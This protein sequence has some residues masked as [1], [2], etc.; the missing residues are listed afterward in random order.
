LVL[1]VNAGL[2]L[3][4]ADWLVLYYAVNQGKQ[5]MIPADSNVVTVGDAS[6]PLPDQDCAGVDLLS[7]IP[8]YA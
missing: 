4:F 7:S 6:A 8:L 1:S 3:L 5:G 2:S